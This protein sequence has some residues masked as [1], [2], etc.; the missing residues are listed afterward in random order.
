MEDGNLYGVRDVI[1][2][3]LPDSRLQFRYVFNNKSECTLDLPV[4]HIQYT[5]CM[6]D[7]ESKSVLE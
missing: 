4:Y 3:T 5:N 6:K 1:D 7:N 2:L